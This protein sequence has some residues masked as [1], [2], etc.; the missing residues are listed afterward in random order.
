MLYGF[1]LVVLLI[2]VAVVSL[3]ID[4]SQQNKAFETRVALLE[5]Q[6]HRLNEKLGRQTQQ[7]QFAAELQ[8]I[9]KQSGEILRK[10]ILNF[11][12]EV[13]ENAFPKK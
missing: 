1:V 10:S 11:N 3:I 9:S 12:F 8:A 7:L 2:V 13:M 6:L 5:N 4:C